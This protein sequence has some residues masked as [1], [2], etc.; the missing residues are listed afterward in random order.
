ME[1]LHE[2]GTAQTTAVPG[3]DGSVQFTGPV[4][5][6]S[7]ILIQVDD[8]DLIADTIDVTLENQT[9]MNYPIRFGAV[10]LM[11]FSGTFFPIT[12][13]PGWIRPA[14]YATPLWHGVALCRAFSLGTVQAGPAAVNVAYLVALAAFGLW[15]GGRTY[16][17]RLYV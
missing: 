11:L 10:P 5:P 4:Y 12:Q 3:H 17:R 1:T 14:A 7:D 8:L 16:Q 15:W 6:G 2:S 13:L 9:P